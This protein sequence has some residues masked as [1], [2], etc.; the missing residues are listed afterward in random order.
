MC[1]TPRVKNWFQKFYDIKAKKYNEIKLYILP[2]FFG[3]IFKNFAHQ[4]PSLKCLKC[5]FFEKF[6]RRD[7]FFILIFDIL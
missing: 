1:R 7:F 6:Y 5:H 3:E 2:V 4:L